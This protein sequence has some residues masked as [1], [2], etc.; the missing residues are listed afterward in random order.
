M[1]KDSSSYYISHFDFA[2]FYGKT[3]SF[4]HNA[5]EIRKQIFENP[6]AS[7]QC[8][9]DYGIAPK[10]TWKSY[11]PEIVKDHIEKFIKTSEYERLKEEY[12]SIKQYKEMWKGSPFPPTFITADFVL[13]C[14]YEYVLV[15]KRKRGLGKGLFALPGGFVKQNETIRNAAI[16]ELREETS[17]NFSPGYLENCIQESK[18][19]DFPER[20]LR[21]RTITQAF[22]G[23][24]SAS[25]LPEVI[26]SDDASEAIWLTYQEIS[27]HRHLFFEDHFYIIQY[28]IQKRRG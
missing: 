17:L 12:D 14:E 5:T 25:I 7:G 19:F 24:I 23:N 21:G 15:V 6:N 22:Y 9:E 16:R 20:S 27:D 10:S 1:F 18:I 26:G 2:E 8:W 13:S 4:Q 11:V 28:F 3:P